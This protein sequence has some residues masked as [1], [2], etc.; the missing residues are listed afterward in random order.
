MRLG[1]D[2]KM[3]C[4]AVGTQNVWAVDRGGRVYLRIGSQPPSEA[5]VNPAWLP[6]PL[7]GSAG[8]TGAQ[9]NLQGI[10][11]VLV[12]TSPNDLHVRLNEMHAY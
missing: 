5:R 8:G 4:I 6:V 3:A 12:S 10:Q 9:T 2:V 1:V 11:F 7:Q